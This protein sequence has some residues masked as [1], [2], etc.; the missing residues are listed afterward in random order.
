MSA[1][2]Q[3]M[4]ILKPFK[5]T[6]YIPQT[7]AVASQFSAKSKLGGFPYLRNAED[8]PV[9][10]NC[11]KHKQLFLQLNMAEL[12]ENQYD[13]LVQFF[14]CTTEK[15]NCESHFGTYF[16]FTDATTCRKIAIE[17]DSPTIEPTI[18]KIY[19]EKQIIGWEAKDDFPHFEEYNLLGIELTD[20]QMEAVENA[21]ILPSQKDKLFGYPYWI[22]GVE[23]PNDRNTGVQMQLLFQIDSD[24]NLPHSFG[25]MGI[26]HLTQSPNNEEEMGFGWACY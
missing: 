5:K 8:W 17:G 10:P 19:E 14:Y 3:A 7:T 20:E 25:D 12:P 22:Q 16:P 24:D 4:E 1:L 9:C 13:G 11:K 21:E 2:E 26:G 18:D 23:Y 6:A 15:P